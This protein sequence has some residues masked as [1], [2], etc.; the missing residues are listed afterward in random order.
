MADDDKRPQ[1][2]IRVTRRETIGSKAWTFSIHPET[3]EIFVVLP[4]LNTTW[5]TEREAD[6]FVQAME[7][8][9]VVAATIMAAYPNGEKPA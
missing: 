7:D 1:P 5:M 8:L 2:L 4:H 3:G 9:P 6:V